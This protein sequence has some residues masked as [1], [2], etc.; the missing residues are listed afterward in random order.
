[1]INPQKLGK[2]LAEDIVN[3]RGI[4]IYPGGFKPPHKGYFEAIK[5]LTARSYIVEILILISNKTIEGITPEDSLYVW[6]TFLKA[7]PNPKVELRF[8][9]DESPINSTFAY[10]NNKKD[11]KAIYI[12]GG[13]EEGDDQ[14]YLE[15]LRKQFPGV[16]K[17]ISVTE[18]L[19]GITDSY[20][21][22]TLR[23]GDKEAFKE[24]MPAVVYNKGYVDEIYNLLAP[25]VAAS[26][27]EEEKPQPEE[28][29]KP[30]D[31]TE[32]A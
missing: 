5:D 19:G 27:P 18:H 24:T 14:S 30:E 16:V 22:Q 32:K 20:V 2:L 13:K 26:K 4:C 25:A 23:L 11:L 12:A 17:T 9:G 8:S 6:S 21:R 1:M 10:I 28:E 3:E 15:D 29:P 7:S 31:D